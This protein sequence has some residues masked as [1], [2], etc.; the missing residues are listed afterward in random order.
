M[1]AGVALRL[2][3][4]ADSDTDGPKKNHK[5]DQ[6]RVSCGLSSFF[7]HSPYFELWIWSLGG[8][9]IVRN[10]F[11]LD[12][13]AHWR[14]GCF[15]LFVF[16]SRRLVFNNST[17][18]IKLNVSF[19]PHH[20]LALYWFCVIVN[21]FSSLLSLHCTKQVLNTDIAS[22]HCSCWQTSSFTRCSNLLH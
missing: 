16:E 15:H 19:L 10:A 11:L 1:S 9:L 18:S 20:F 21:R 14:V 5:T 17:T 22:R 6:H 8:T 12:F 4:F 7:S 13:G 3:R 2:H